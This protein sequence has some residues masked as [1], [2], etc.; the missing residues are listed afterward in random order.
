[1]DRE[2]WQATYSFAQLSKEWDKTATNNNIMLNDAQYIV[3]ES[4]TLKYW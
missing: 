4:I 1:M 3:R 2:A